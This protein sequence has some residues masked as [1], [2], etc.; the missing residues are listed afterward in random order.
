MNADRIVLIAAIVI[1]LVLAGDDLTAHWT[2][3][4]PLLVGSALTTPLHGGSR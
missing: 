1:G 3:E 2:G 4:P